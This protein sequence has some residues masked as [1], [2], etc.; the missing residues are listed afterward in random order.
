MY[1]NA[2]ISSQKAMLS[3]PAA[4]EA[5]SQEKL[6]KVACSAKYPTRSVPVLPTNTTS[7]WH[8]NACCCKSID[9]RMYPFDRVALALSMHAYMLFVKFL[10]LW[11]L[12]TSDC[13]RALPAKPARQCPLPL[14]HML[15]HVS[16]RR[17]ATPERK[18]PAKGTA[19]IVADSSCDMLESTPILR[20]IRTGLSDIDGERIGAGL[21]S[22]VVDLYSCEG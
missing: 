7:N 17:H 19:F 4:A 13:E 12:I 18:F 2:K 14:L 22:F 6:L 15:Q 9:I 20:P 5:F 10:C 8:G 11:Q 3:Q 16:Q 21:V 1:S